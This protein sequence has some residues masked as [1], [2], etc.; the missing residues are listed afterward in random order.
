[1]QNGGG[2]SMSDHERKT[3]DRCLIDGLPIAH[4]IAI[5]YRKFTFELAEIQWL[6]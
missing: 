1:M 4:F 6:N 5:I 2:N 3:F